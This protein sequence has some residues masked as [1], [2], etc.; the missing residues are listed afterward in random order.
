MTW[1][2]IE[3]VQTLDTE[4]GHP[5]SPFS[6]PADWE[7]G[8]TEYRNWLR[9]QFKTSP[10][11]RQRLGIAARRYAKRETLDFQGRFGAVLPDILDS[12][13]KKL[14]TEPSVGD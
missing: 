3:D 9:S 11:V 4:P 7:G 1:K 2:F 8:N 10:W 6:P 13:L 5:D 14:Q 12:I